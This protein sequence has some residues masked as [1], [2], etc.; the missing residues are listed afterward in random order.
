MTGHLR[1]HKVI[2]GTRNQSHLDKNLGAIAINIELTTLELHEINTA[3]AK[4]KVQNGWRKPSLA[5]PI[6]N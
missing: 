4:V 5:I 3:L 6:A 2:P 1:K